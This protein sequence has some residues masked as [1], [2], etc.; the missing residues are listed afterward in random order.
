MSTTYL[1]CVFAFLITGEYRA[2]GRKDA[3]AFVEQLN[4]DDFEGCLSVDVFDSPLES[5]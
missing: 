1:L 5:E 4:A 2:F 3:I